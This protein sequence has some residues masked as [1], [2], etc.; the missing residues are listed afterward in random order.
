MGN[1]GRWLTRNWADT[2]ESGDPV[3]VP[4]RLTLPESEAVAR[5]GEVI[6]SLPRWRVEASDP[7]AGTLRATRR[8][9]LFR[10]VDDVA[11]RVESDGSGRS[12]LHARSQSRLGKGDFGQN[13]R[14][15]LE[16]FAALGRAGLL[17][18]GDG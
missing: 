6:A 4:R 18:E 12:V 17:R 5:V 8:T 11:L 13:R 2:A 9:R 7:V 15:L 16:L 3:I 10:F 14:N 1:L